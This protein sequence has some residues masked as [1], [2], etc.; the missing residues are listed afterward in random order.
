MKRF[1][2]LSGVLLTAACG[3]SAVNEGE[4]YGD[5][6]AS[7]AGLVLTEAEHEVG[8]GVAECTLC[9]NLE[10]IHLVNRTTL[11]IDV[12]AIHEQTLDEGLAG[13]ATCHGTNGVP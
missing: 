5:L 11:S 12:E 9:H 8:W 6:L 3:G 13:C 4:N 1:W 2:I 10:N 7:P